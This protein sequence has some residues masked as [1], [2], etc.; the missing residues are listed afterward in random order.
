[1]PA[2]ALPLSADRFSGRYF[3]NSS[4]TNLFALI[5]FLLFPSD[6]KFDLANVFTTAITNVTPMN[7]AIPNSG[8]PA[9]G[10]ASTKLLALPT[11]V[12]GAS[13]STSTSAPSTVST[14]S[15]VSTTASPPA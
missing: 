14:V 6:V 8:Y 4:I 10:F 13:T 15:T 11:S 5:F 1:M 12:A 3:C 2:M 9:I 7:P